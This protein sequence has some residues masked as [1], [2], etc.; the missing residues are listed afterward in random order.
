M[1]LMLSDSATLEA[2]LPINFHQSRGNRSIEGDVLH[3]VKVR[4]QGQIQMPSEKALQQLLFQSY[5]LQ[6]LAKHKLLDLD[7]Y[8][9]G[10]VYLHCFL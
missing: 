10:I 4:N 1:S 9:A 5:V 2:E 6:I 7:F 3:Y 8:P